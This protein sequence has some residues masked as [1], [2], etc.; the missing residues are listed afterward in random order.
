MSSNKHEVHNTIR[1]YCRD[2]YTAFPPPPSLKPWDVKLKVRLEGDLYKLG[3]HGLWLGSL[4][5]NQV[6]Y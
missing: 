1:S 2:V 5:E 3:L 4:V 6:M